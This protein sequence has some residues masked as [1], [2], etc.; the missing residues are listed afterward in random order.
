MSRATEAAGPPAQDSAVLKSQGK[1]PKDELVLEGFFA[2]VTI[3]RKL[4]KEA[5]CDISWYKNSN[6][7][8]H[9][10]K[11]PDLEIKQGAIVKTEAFETGKHEVTYGT[12]HGL[13]RKLHTAHLVRGKCLRFVNDK[14]FPVDFDATNFKVKFHQHRNADATGET[15]GEMWLWVKGKW[16]KQDYPQGTKKKRI[17][18]KSAWINAENLSDINLRGAELQGSLFMGLNLKGADLR[19]AQLQNTRF[20]D[21]DLSHARFGGASME[22]SNFNAAVMPH[23]D[24]SSFIDASGNPICTHLERAT[25]HGANLKWA[26]FEFSSAAGT[27][28]N[29]ADLEEA[30]LE[31]CDIDSDTT[32][33]GAQNIVSAHI[34]NITFSGV[35]ISWLDV[36]KLKQVEQAKALLKEKDENR[37]GGGGSSASSLGDSLNDSLVSLAK[38]NQ[39]D[40][41]LPPPMCATYVK[42]KRNIGKWI[43][44]TAM[45]GGESESDD[46]DDHDVSGDDDDD[47]DGGGGGDDDADADDD[48]GGGDDADDADGRTMQNKSM[49]VICSRL[50]CCAMMLRRE[51]RQLLNGLL[52]QLRHAAWLA[53]TL[54]R[55]GAEVDIK[56]A[57]TNIQ[58]IQ[59]QQ[60]QPLN[61]VSANTKPNQAGTNNKIKP[62]LVDADGD[63]L[64]QLVKHMRASAEK[65]G[66]EENQE[67]KKGLEKESI[68]RLKGCVVKHITN[69]L[70]SALRLLLCDTTLLED[71]P[72]K[73]KAKSS[74][75]DD[76]VEGGSG[77]GAKVVAMAKAKKSVA[78]MDRE[79]L[80]Q[81]SDMD[82]EDELQTLQERFCKAVDTKARAMVHGWTA[83]GYER[84][85]KRVKAKRCRHCRSCTASVSRFVAALR[86]FDSPVLKQHIRELEQIRGLVDDLVRLEVKDSNLDEVVANWNLLY[87]MSS[88]LTCRAGFLLLRR[89]VWTPDTRLALLL[90]RGLTTAHTPYPPELVRVFKSKATVQLREN[91]LEI[92]KGVNGTIAAIHRIQAYKTQAYHL[93]GSVLVACLIGVANFLSRIGFD[94]T[95]QSSVYKQYFG[96]DEQQQP[97]SPQRHLEAAARSSDD[98]GHSGHEWLGT[99]D[100]RK[101]MD[102]GGIF[103]SSGNTTPTAALL[104]REVVQ[105]LPML[106]LAAIA[107]AYV[108]TQLGLERAKLKEL[109][110]LKEQGRHQHGQQQAELHRMNEQ[111]QV[112]A[113]AGREGL[114]HS[115]GKR[116]FH[117]GQ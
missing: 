15:N 76:E 54:L 92:L 28:F 83:Q 21:A 114:P 101:S 116:G 87:S 68:L 38:M 112:L 63:T 13:A 36:E 71:A 26:N 99:M 33:Q 11:D 12:S 94:F 93:M 69:L 8:L 5:G 37:D 79:D 96:A 111:L 80:Q 52:A 34:S 45:G 51:D 90:G 42:P 110:E 78:D 86:E 41:L 62:Q 53:H 4:A 89:Y 81:L 106:L 58:I 56:Q 65:Y 91:Y 67:L 100:D 55:Q 18:L 73:A 60:Q 3:D 74:G 43:L 14:E 107:A 46:G 59:K 104:A 44:S 27:Q 88:K 30:K 16:K 9:L 84:F 25:F 105:Q 98:G 40:A 31:R 1:T 48:D 70:K 109:K 10:S 115:A 82:W 72:K 117:E 22:A 50:A 57:A 19:R 108:Y 64:A 32:F 85:S 47:D 95:S 102:S 29:R 97:S 61:R 103:G 49:V 20:S 75:D 39:L 2:K 35:N 17:W 23:T 66:H 77:G 113:S 24:F 7:P 6:L